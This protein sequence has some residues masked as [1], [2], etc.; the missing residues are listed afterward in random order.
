MYLWTPFPRSLSRQREL[1]SPL[2]GRHS[3]GTFPRIVS[4]RK[5]LK[6]KPDFIG[7]ILEM[8]AINRLPQECCHA[9]IGC[10]ALSLTQQHSQEVRNRTRASK[11]GMERKSF[12]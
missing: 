5:L 9:E 12:H 10:E 3:K 7:H 1:N 2:A 4:N 6:M 11:Q 8:K